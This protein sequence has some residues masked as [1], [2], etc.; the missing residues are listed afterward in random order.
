MA[1][2]STAILGA[3]GAAAA[4]AT[5]ATTMK[6]AHDQKKAAKKAQE[7]AAKTPVYNAQAEKQKAAKQEAEANRRRVMSETDTVQ[8]TALGNAGTTELKKKTLLGG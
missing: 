2:A 8:T 1:V 7:A 6:Q 4:V 5:A 3:I